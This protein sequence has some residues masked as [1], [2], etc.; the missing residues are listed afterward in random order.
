MLD[1]AAARNPA[2]VGKALI[3]ATEETPVSD[4][5]WNPKSYLIFLS[6]AAAKLAVF[7]RF[8]LHRNLLGVEWD[9]C[10][11]GRLPPLPSDPEDIYKFYASHRSRFVYPND[12]QDFW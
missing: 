12:V 11:T 1:S 2:L 7:D 3:Q 8:D 6:P 4:F 5:L 10:G 9:V